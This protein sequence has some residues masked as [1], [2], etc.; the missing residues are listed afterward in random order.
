MNLVRI[1][2]KIQLLSLESSSEDK[3]SANGIL[4]VTLG[5]VFTFF[6]IGISSVS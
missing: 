3:V 1:P 5:S 2:V 4:I 6:L